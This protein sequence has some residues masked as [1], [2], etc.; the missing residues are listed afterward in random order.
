MTIGVGSFV[1]SYGFMMVELLNRIRDSGEVRV[2]Y[3]CSLYKGVW[4]EQ[5]L[6]CTDWKVNKK[7]K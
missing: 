4:K 3:A 5:G 1:F 7:I 6:T 2:Y